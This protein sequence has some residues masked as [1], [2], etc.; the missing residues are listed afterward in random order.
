MGQ[1]GDGGTSQ[2]NAPTAVSG[3]MTFADITSGF[4][5]T[6]GIRTDGRAYCWG[7]NFS[8]ELG[9]NGASGA[10]SSTPVAVS[11]G[12]TW[13]QLAAG[14]GFGIEFTCGVTSSSQTYCW[15]DGSLGQLGDG[16]KTSHK[17]P[18]PVAGGG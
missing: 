5:Q 17:V 15:G 3:G 18:T 2:R 12:L 11:G 9:D 14:S 8:G 1:I 10:K 7:D 13:T 6:C 16:L 4:R